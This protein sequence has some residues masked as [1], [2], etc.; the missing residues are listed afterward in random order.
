LERIGKVYE[1]EE[2]TKGMSAEE[3]LK[4][5]QTRSGPFMEELKEWMER[6]TAEK[7]VEPNSSLGKATKY[8][9]NNYPGLS[10]FS[11]AA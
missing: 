1:N 7:R 4:Y 9:L 11:M 5:H 3:R 10:A 8:F 2:A 6:E